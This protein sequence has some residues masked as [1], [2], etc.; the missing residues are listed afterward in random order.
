MSCDENC[1]I[2]NPLTHPTSLAL[3]SVLLFFFIYSF[4]LCDLCSLNILFCFFRVFNPAF[5]VLILLTLGKIDFRL[6]PSLNRKINPAFSVLIL[7]TLGK[8]D[9]RLLPSLNRKIALDFF[10]FSIL[11][12][13]FIGNS[14]LSSG[15]YPLVN[16]YSSQTGES[17][18]A[19]KSQSLAKQATLQ[20]RSSNLDT[21]FYTLI[22]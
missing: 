4:D 19:K 16:I 12:C 8:I 3:L 15:L 20:Q 18:E 2:N 7:L 5:A 17:C 14:Y 22:Y 21:A 6:L 9:F 10:F 13:Q 1:V 11:F